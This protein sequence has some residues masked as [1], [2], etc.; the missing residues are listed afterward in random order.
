M[1]IALALLLALSAGTA[2]GVGYVLKTHT[3][4]FGNPE[5]TEEDGSEWLNMAASDFR[6]V[7]ATLVPDVPLPAG[8][9]WDPEL[10]RM[11]AWGRAEPAM[12]QQPRAPASARGR[13]RRR[14]PPEWRPARRAAA[15]P[16]RPVS[17][18]DRSARLLQGRSW[19]SYSQCPAERCS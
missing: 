2:L 5:H 14:L 4:L 1:V 8:V 18:R 9:S 7:A 12:M 19:L 6:A 16:A 13:R 10:D 17:G 3:G 11:A 15:P